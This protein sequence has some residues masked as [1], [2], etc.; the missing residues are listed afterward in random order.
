MRP[1][2]L[3][4]VS[5][6][7]SDMAKGVLP[8]TLSGAED[9]GGICRDSRPRHPPLRPP[10]G[11]HRG[12][13]GQARRAHG[14]KR[15]AGAALRQPQGIDGSTSGSAPARITRRLDLREAGPADRGHPGIRQLA[16]HP[17]FGRT[18]RLGVPEPS[19]GKTHRGRRAMEERRA[20]ADPLVGLRRKRESPPIS[21]PASWA[22]S[23]AAGPAGASSTAAGF[24]G[25]IA[26]DQLW[27][28]YPDE[29]ID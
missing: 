18:G 24:S 21:S 2:S 8:E 22:R 14:G 9:A 4:G 26:R 6:G 15:P 16:P 27:G 17:R 20:A 23:S 13:F 5:R 29:D 10:I 25:W 1:R 3:C 19:L 12:A 28:V 11:H 7:V